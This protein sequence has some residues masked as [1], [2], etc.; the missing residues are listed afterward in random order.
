MIETN[1]DSAWMD[2]M[3]M[4]NVGYPEFSEMPD[5]GECQ[6]A[7][8]GEASCAGDESC[9]EWFESSLLSPEIRQLVMGSEKYDGGVGRA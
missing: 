9:S 3:P 1:E 6:G 2:A 4:V 7:K 5:F 8:E